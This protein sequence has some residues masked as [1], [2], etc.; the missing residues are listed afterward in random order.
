M[1]KLNW[2]LWTAQLPPGSSLLVRASSVV[3]VVS[4]VVEGG[5]ERERHGVVAES[6]TR[7]HRVYHTRRV[8]ERARRMRDNE[9]L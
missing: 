9:V 1:W 4:Y 2:L 7:Q 8:K 5:R 6:K 3:V